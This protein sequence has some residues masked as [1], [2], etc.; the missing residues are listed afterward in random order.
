MTYSNGMDAHFLTRHLSAKVVVAL[1]PLDIERGIRNE[2]YDN[3]H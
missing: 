2:D 3:W 1:L